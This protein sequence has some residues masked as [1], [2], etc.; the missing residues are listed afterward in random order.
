MSVSAT[1]GVTSPF[2][3]PTD[4]SATSGTNSLGDQNT[5]LQ[6]MVAQMKYQDPMN[7]TDSSQFLSQT[8]QFTALEKMTSVADQM[9]S[10][11]QS[12]MAFGAG[13]MIGKS[14]QWTDDNG[15]TQ[16]GTVTG[17]SFLTTGPT[18]TING[19]SVPLTSVTSVGDTTSS[20]SSSTPSTSTTSSST[21]V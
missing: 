5:F 7:P 18:L 17:A 1:E 9:S 16:S 20:S 6:L 14:V 19:S 11:V 2:T 21:A 10:L 12:Q 4:Q 15:A 8:A 13:A 3:T